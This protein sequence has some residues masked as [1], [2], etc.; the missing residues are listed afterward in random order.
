[1]SIRSPR[2]HSSIAIA[3]HMPRSPI[4]GTST[5]ASPSRTIQMLHRFIM[6]GTNG[7]DENG[8]QIIIDDWGERFILEDWDG[9]PRWWEE[10]QYSH[11]HPHIYGITC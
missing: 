8:N 3:I 11:M 10:P 6:L 7:V 1:M 5:S 9:G 4:R 2:T